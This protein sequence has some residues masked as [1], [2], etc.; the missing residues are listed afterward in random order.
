MIETKIDE[1]V[2]ALSA[3]TAAL[4][5]LGKG[6]PAAAGAPAETAAAKKKREA[7]EAAAAAAAS[8]PAGPTLDD[9][10]TIAGKIVEAGQGKKI[11]ELAKKHGLARVSAAF[12]TDKA[13]EVYDALKAIDSSL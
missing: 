7:A 5:A 6:P 10:R 12:G 4:L 3:N 11:E 8:A 13:Q 2:A 1:L 9:F